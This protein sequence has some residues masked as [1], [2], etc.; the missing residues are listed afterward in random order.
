MMR[1]LLHN[2]PGPTA[3]SEYE[4]T[5]IVDP[6]TDQLE[7]AVLDHFD[8]IL[9]DTHTGDAFIT[10][11]AVGDDG[12]HAAKNA[13]MELL[14]LGVRIDRLEYDLADRAE[15]ADRLG[16]TP[17]AIGNYIRGTRHAASPF[18]RAFNEVRGGVWL[19]ADVVEWARRVLKVDPGEGL[20]FPNR[21]EITKFNSCFERGYSAEPAAIGYGAYRMFFGGGVVN[22]SAGAGLF[23]DE[24][25]AFGS[26]A[27]WLK[28]LTEKLQ[29][30]FPAAHRIS[31]VSPQL[32]ES[33]Q[34]V[35]IPPG[36]I[37]RGYLE[38]S[39]TTQDHQVEPEDEDRR[40]ER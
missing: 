1:Q 3:M 16:A 9:G 28:I 22:E 21:V 35:V 32:H 2:E 17:Q 14:G 31:Y 33:F 36:D 40:V 26:S 12:F 11:T 7:V 15:L 23:A 8:C 13:H 29:Q 4:L 34:H 20:E 6:M 37:F 24:A 5:F 19:W 18:P 10:L 30:G 27:S 25:S 39:A 38:S